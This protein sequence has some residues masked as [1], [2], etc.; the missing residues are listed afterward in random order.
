MNLISS[1]HVTRYSKLIK[2]QR[3]DKTNRFHRGKRRY[4]LSRKKKKENIYRRRI[5]R[6]AEQS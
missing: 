6:R 4:D 3:S 5:K 2:N 1:M